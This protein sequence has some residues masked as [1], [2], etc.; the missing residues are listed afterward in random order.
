MK[1][2][3]FLLALT[4]GFTGCSSKDSTDTDLTDLDMEAV[5]SMHD[6][7][8]PVDLD[9]FDMVVEDS[10]DADLVE[11][12]TLNLYVLPTILRDGRW[13]SYDRDVGTVIGR[14]GDRFEVT[15][16]RNDASV[17]DI[18]RFRTGYA[19]VRQGAEGAVLE[20][21]A[22]ADSLEPTKVLERP[23]CLTLLAYGDKLLL[24]CR[25][26]FVF[27]EETL[28][29]LEETRTISRASYLEQFPRLG[30]PLTRHALQGDTLY[31][32]IVPQPN[33]LQV[34]A[35]DL[36][37]Q[38]EE[39]LLVGVSE[40]WEADNKELSVSDEFLFVPYRNEVQMVALF[41]HE[42]FERVGTW[43]ID[44]ET[45]EFRNNGTGYANDDWFIITHWKSNRRYAVVLDATSQD[46]N[47]LGAIPFVGADP[48]SDFSVILVDQNILYRTQERLTF[49]WQPYALAQISEIQLED[50]PL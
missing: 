35:W 43:R 32:K 24:V 20:Y 30:T 8:S 18:T 6:S 11:G 4:F 15:D 21:Y 36:A 16:Y 17:G 22:E 9:T 12:P 27:V 49:P 48:P 26:K 47:C 45:T 39:S 28:L 42:P 41:S 38:D 1:H 5:D 46:L 40:T 3:A 29:G 50:C 31:E 13:V 33:S 2:L 34:I 25:D 14:I 37:A 10:T 19:M 23:S 7:D 44:E